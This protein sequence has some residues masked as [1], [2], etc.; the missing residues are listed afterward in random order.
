M[1]N[2]GS[3]RENSISVLSRARFVFDQAPARCELNQ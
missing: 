2:S 3:S 1:L